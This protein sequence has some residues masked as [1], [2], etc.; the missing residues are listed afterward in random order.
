MWLANDH[1]R[2]N[3]AA[4]AMLAGA[5]LGCGSD[6]GGG[7]PG[8]ITSAVKS[9][10]PATS[11]QPTPSATTSAPGA[12]SVGTTPAEGANPLVGTWKGSY[13]AEKI[14]PTLDPTVKDEVWRDDDGTRHTGPGRI[15]LAIAHD[16]TTS[17]SIEGALGASDLHGT[18]DGEMVRATIVPRG[19]DAAGGTLIGKRVD[20][21][22]ALELRTSDGAGKTPRVARA[23]LEK[24]P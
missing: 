17:G 10:A 6:E 21:G 8:A 3:G 2:W 23:T 14:K 9:A 13:R 18:S 15:E 16:G 19:D 7:A 12:S 4:V 20:K 1:F 22:L 11:A 5:L 24:S